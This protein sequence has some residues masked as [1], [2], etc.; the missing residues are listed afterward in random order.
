MCEGFSIKKTAQECNISLKTAFIWRYKI[1]DAFTVKR[2]EVKLSGIIEADETFF[3]LSYKGTK[4]LSSLTSRMP[5]YRGGKA[6][7]RGLSKDQVC[8]VCAI[9]R[10]G[11]TFSKVSNLGKISSND[12]DTIYHNKIE[13]DAIFC[14]DSEKSYKQFIK[15]NKYKIV[16]IPRGKHKNGVYH[17]NH[18]NSFHNNLKHFTD[19]FRGI[20]T[21]YLSNYLSWVHIINMNVIEVLKYIIS[22]THCVRCVDIFNRP[23]VPIYIY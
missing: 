21:K 20:S 6:E 1:L 14:T 16:Q 11:T 17:I 4:N 23:S 9:D 19:K 5:K 2:E 8:V 22:I 13:G 18:I 3:R 15:K 7:R 10:K 12:L